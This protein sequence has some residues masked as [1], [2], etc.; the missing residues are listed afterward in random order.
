MGR[1]KAT[2]YRKYFLVI[3]ILVVLCTGCEDLEPPQNASSDDEILPELELFGAFVRYSRGDKPMF[4]IE[5][6]LLSRFET[7]KILHFK[8]GIKIDFYDRDGL[9]N[10]VMTSEEGEVM[11]RINKLVARGNV[12]VESDSGLVLLTDELYYIQQENRVI[13]NTF[14]TVITNNDSLTGVGF[15]ATPDLSDWVILNSSGTTW[16]NTDELH[17]EQ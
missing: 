15:S 12:V 5:A 1:G 8:G 13:S 4:T 9:H 6:P 3:L 7:R 10:A 11:E 16:R 14:V 2:V 17:K